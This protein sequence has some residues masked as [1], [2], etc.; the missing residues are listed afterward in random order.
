MSDRDGDN[1]L[2]HTRNANAAGTACEEDQSSVV[3]D[4]VDDHDEKNPTT[5]LHHTEETSSSSESDSPILNSLSS[6]EQ[7]QE[8]EGISLLKQIFP[9][10]SPSALKQLHLDHIRAQSKHSSQQLQPPLSLQPKSRLGRR[11][12][13]QVIK[14]QK[15]E[16]QQ[17]Q[18]QSASRQNYPLHWQPVELPE[19]FLR[20][21][22][23]VAVYRYQ[24][25]GGCGYELVKDLER[26]ALQQEGDVTTTASTNSSYFTEVLV[27]D[28]HLGLG[29]TLCYDDS[30]GERLRVQIQPRQE[31]G[32]CYKA[33]IRPGD[34]LIGLNGESFRFVKFPN[35][36]LLQYAATAIQHSPNPIVLHLKRENQETQLSKA[37][38]TS[39]TIP[40]QHHISRPVSPP[41]S[42]GRLTSLLDATS[43]L[44]TTSD[45]H[46]QSYPVTR[47]SSASASPPRNVAMAPNQSEIHPFAK[48]LSDRGLLQSTN[49]KYLRVYRCSSLFC[50]ERDGLLPIYR[51][52]TVLLHNPD[53]IRR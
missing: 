39:T 31:E 36:S 5:P 22:I 41:E 26:R 53:V 34:T 28:A 12:W 7:F 1:G 3:N 18:Q 2:H 15:Q 9:D 16:Q 8:M 42:V 52:Y 13:K 19:T 46:E 21:P 25:D 14:L 33:G 4:D 23:S 6:E 45:D 20:L 40:S 47:E 48:S 29:M 49:G 50:H 32:P 10:E 44:D 27:R 17:Q 43:L 11:I 37:H 51:V 38:S 24:P 30:K 35:M